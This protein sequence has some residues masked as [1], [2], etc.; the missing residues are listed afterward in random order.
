M[1]PILSNDSQIAT[2]N[3][4]IPQVTHIIRIEVLKILLLTRANSLPFFVVF[5]F[6]NPYTMGY[7]FFLLSLWPLKEEAHIPIPT[8]LLKSFLHFV[9]ISSLSTYSSIHP[10][11]SLITIPLWV[12]IK[13]NNLRILLNILDLSPTWPLSSYSTQLSFLFLIHFFHVLACKLIY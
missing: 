6:Q 10:D 8:K 3:D 5:C 4:K 12:L 9:S 1:N 7:P 2:Y 13:I 11:L